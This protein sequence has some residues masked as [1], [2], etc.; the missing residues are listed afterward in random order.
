MVM[1]ISEGR[2]NFRIGCVEFNCNSG[3]A[4]WREGWSQDK[5]RWCCE[6]K[7]KG[8]KGDT[9][10]DELADQ[11]EAA[12]SSAGKSKIY[13]EDSE[14]DE[15]HDYIINLPPSWS[16]DSV[17]AFQEKAC[18]KV[19]EHGG[20][21]CDAPADGGGDLRAVQIRASAKWA[22]TSVPAAALAG[23]VPPP[24][25]GGAPGSC[26]SGGDV[27]EVLR[28]AV[29]V[30]VR[31]GGDLRAVQIRAS[32][33]WAGTS[34][35]PPRPRRA[36]LGDPPH[37]PAVRSATRGA[38]RRPGGRGAPPLRGGRSGLLPLR[39]RRAGGV[40]LRGACGCGPDGRLRHAGPVASCRVHAAA[41]SPQHRS[42]RMRSPLHAAQTRPTLSDPL[43]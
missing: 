32:A 5:K 9:G 24:S 11:D 14:D 17:R 39:W 6:Q 7:Q 20:M 21:K 22:G 12:E 36:R 23:G 42:R 34:A 2:G 40:A 31:A 41:T 27:P 37:R 15:Q 43:C 19:E 8:C 13:G 35:P 30:R 25:A 3:Y 1:T 33:K 29:C 38:R 26:R 4:N 18:K 16:M 28:C 10:A